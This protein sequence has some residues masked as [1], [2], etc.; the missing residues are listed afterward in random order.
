M[1]G[2]TLRPFQS[3]EKLAG[4]KVVGSYLQLL[5]LPQLQEGL[6]ELALHSEKLALL[7]LLH[8]LGQLAVPLL[9]CLLQQLTYQSLGLAHRLLPQLLRQ[10]GYC[11]PHLLPFA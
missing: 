10:L 9:F 3:A 6:G 5:Y 8:Q 11:C 2:L 1:S 4:H 7:L